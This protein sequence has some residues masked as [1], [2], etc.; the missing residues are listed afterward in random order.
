MG[1]L[2]KTRESAGTGVDIAG[3]FTLLTPLELRSEFRTKKGAFFVTTNIADHDAIVLSIIARSSD[4]VQLVEACGED[5]AKQIWKIFGKKGR[6]VVKSFDD[7]NTV[8]GLV[9]VT[10]REL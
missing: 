6:V 1:K 4:P 2:Y 8:L 5:I 10:I 7:I 9:E 3:G